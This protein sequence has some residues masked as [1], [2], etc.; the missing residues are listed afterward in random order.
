LARQPKKDVQALYDH[1]LSFVP[2]TGEIAYDQLYAAVQG[3]SNPEAISMLPELK[4]RGAVTSH[5]EVIDGVKSHTY[6]RK[7]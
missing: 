5:I 4:R 1:A 6:S 2:E 3:S 7:V